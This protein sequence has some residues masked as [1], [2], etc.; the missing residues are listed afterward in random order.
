[1]RGDILFKTFFIATGLLLFNPFVYAQ[2]VMMKIT[3]TAFDHNAM[4]PRKY[5]CQGEDISPPLAISGI[6]EGTVALALIN[7][8]PDAPGGTWDHWIVHLRTHS[9]HSESARYYAFVALFPPL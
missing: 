4:I 2:E 7:D 8:D 5:T 3:S 1:M 6:P 9:F